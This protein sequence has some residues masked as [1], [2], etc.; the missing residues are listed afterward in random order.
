MLRSFVPPLEIPAQTD[1]RPEQQITPTYEATQCIGNT[2]T[3]GP[4]VYPNPPCAGIASRSQPRSF[5]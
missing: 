5:S 4:V 3:L 1:P 2:H